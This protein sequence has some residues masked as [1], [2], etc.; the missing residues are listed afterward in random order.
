ME[1]E[2]I[3]AS[4]S[5]YITDVFDPYIKLLVEAGAQEE[6]AKALIR[7]VYALGQ[8]DAILGQKAEI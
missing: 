7:A 6:T 4:L 2:E 5:L 8:I 3:A 1:A